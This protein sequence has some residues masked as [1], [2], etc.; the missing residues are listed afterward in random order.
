MKD[1]IPISVCIVTYKIISKI[2][3]DKLGKML[4]SVI[5][6][7]QAAFVSSQNIHNHIMLAYEII[8]G[9]T[10]KEE[11]YNYDTD[12]SPKGL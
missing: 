12:R 11:P 5:S 1:Y 4:P 2:L 7:N 9:Y 10:K 6:H 8:K 3:T